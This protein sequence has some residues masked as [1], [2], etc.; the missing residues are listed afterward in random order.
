MDR[1]DKF[2]KKLSAEQRMRIEKLVGQIIKNELRRLDVKKLRG[3]QNLYRVKKGNIR[4]IFKK[5][6]GQGAVIISIERRKENTYK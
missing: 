6:S 3:S 5:V 2:L 1:I 4:I